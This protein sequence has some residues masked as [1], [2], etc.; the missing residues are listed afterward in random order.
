MDFLTTETLTVMAIGLIL[1]IASLP[2]KNQLGGRQSSNWAWV[3]TLT[4][5]WP[6]FMAAWI[7][8]GINILLKKAT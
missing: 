4:I 5:G 2:G 1:G 3:A 6:M 8:V 7:W